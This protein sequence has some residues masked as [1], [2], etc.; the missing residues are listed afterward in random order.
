[1]DAQREKEFSDAINETGIPFQDKCLDIVSKFGRGNEL[2]FRSF[3]EVP[4]THPRT[5]GSQLGK[6]GTIDFLAISVHQGVSSHVPPRIYLIVECKRANPKYKAWIFPSMQDKFH[7]YSGF[8]VGSYYHEIL[9]DKN[10]EKQC[11]LAELK[12]VIFPSLGYNTER[13]FQNVAQG[14]EYNYETK[15]INRDDNKEK[16]DAFL[17]QVNTGLSAFLSEPIDMKII[18]DVPKK[19]KGLL[20][21]PVLVTT[22]N[23][24]TVGYNPEKVSITNG[25]VSPDEIK[26]NENVPWLT[27]NYPLP[28]YLI[29]GTGE[30]KRSTFIVNANSFDKF[31]SGVVEAKIY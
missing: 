10:L 25:N 3:P 13:N 2:F 17:K 5:K 21:L 11:Y 4:Y 12:K 20:F 15:K 26:I 8:L 23:L 9:G 19:E 28:D 18:N 29:P 31:L 16:I 30:E 14:F 24:Y 27:Y 1:M 6:S 7:E 22:A